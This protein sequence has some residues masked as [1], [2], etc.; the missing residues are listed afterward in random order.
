[1]P[2]QIMR[3]QIPAD[4]TTD[5][6]EFSK[7]NP[8][9]RLATIRTGLDVCDITIAIIYV[10]HMI[11]F[12]GVTIWSK[13]IC[14]SFWHERHTNSH[15]VTSASA[16]ASHVALWTRECGSYH[17]RSLCCQILGSC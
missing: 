6:V 2:G 4:K 13:R 5:V 10:P 15:F 1:M 9:Q 17:C 16:S 14:S 3:K 8:A 12:Q 7:M 11:F